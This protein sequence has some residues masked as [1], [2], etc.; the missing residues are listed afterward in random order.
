M[1]LSDTKIKTIKPIE[2]PF[3]LADERGLFLLVQPK[4]SALNR[5][6]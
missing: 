3:K 1:A 6:E 2:K 5:F 4:E